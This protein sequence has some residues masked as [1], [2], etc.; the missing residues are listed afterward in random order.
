MYH[1]LPVWGNLFSC[2]KFRERHT[3]TIHYQC[4]AIRFHTVNFRERDACTT[5][6][7]TGAHQ[8]VMLLKINPR[9]KH[10]MPTSVLFLQLMMAPIFLLWQG[11]SFHPFI[12]LSIVFNVE[13]VSCK[14]EL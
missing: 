10:L 14:F 11:L 1:S 2:G 5:F 6:D 4:G 3:R 13:E 12:I 7:Y 8:I 9:L